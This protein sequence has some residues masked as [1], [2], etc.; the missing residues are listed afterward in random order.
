MSTHTVPSVADNDSSNSDGSSAL[1]DQHEDTGLPVDDPRFFDELGI[2]YLERHTISGS[3]QAAIE[4]FK[5]QMEMTPAEQADLPTVRDLVGSF[6]RRFGDSRDLD[7]L[8]EAIKYQELAL[9][10]TP[11]GHADLPTRL[12]NLGLSFLRRFENT[13]DLKDISAAI[14]YQQRAL[15]LTPVGHA[16][17]P[18]RFNNLGSSFLQRFEQNGDLNDVSE[19]IKYQ[20]RALQLI[21]DGHANLPAW[22]SNCGLSFLRR[23]NHAGNLIDISEAITYQQRA[24]KLT[25]DGHP[26][27]PTWLSNLGLSFSRRFEHTGDL[28]NLSEAIKYQERALQLTPAGHADLPTKLCNLGVSFLRRFEHTT[29][30]LN[31]ISEAIKYHQR[32]LQLTSEGPAKLQT[33]LNNLGVS[34]VCRFGHTG[35]LNDISEAIKYQQHSLQITP[36]GHS[37]LPT[38]L[39]NLGV[40][41]LRRFEH[42]GDLNDI[43]E[44][45]KYKQRALQLAPAG[46]AHLPTWLSNLGVSFS[47]RFER[48]GDLNDVSEAIKSHQRAL[49]LTPDG[50]AKLPNWL[51]HLGISFSRRF[52]CT[53][54]LNDISEAIKYQ[55]RALQ[56]IPDEHAKLPDWLSNLGISFSL[57]FE[58]TGDLNDL[59][60]AIKY[61]EHAL[62]LTPDGHAKLPNWLSNLGLS[63]LR[64]FEHTGDLNHISNAIKYYRRAVQLTPAGH[65]DLPNRLNSLGLSFSHHFE[66]SGDLQC[67]A[68]AESN[69]RLSATS[70]I[71]P[72][73]VRLLAAKRWA[74]L[75]RM[76][77]VPSSHLLDAHACIIELLTLVSGLETTVQRRHE[78][79]VDSSQ[80][81]TAA[82]AAALSL[83]HPDKA[84]E[85]LVEG[86]C[87]IWNQINQ[88]RTPVD[89]LRAH[90]RALADRFSAVSME[91][92]VAGSRSESRTISSETSL[93]TEDK[94]S[95]E[96]QA[97]KH[98]KLAKERDQL[99][100]TIRNIPSFED[101][102]RPKKCADIIRD[103]PEEG[104]SVIINIHEDRCDALAL[105]AGA[106]EPMHIPLPK[107]SY[108]EAECLA[109]GL[110]DYL[111]HCGVISRKIMLLKDS[112]NPSVCGIDLA[113]VLSVLWSKVVL[114]ILESLR[115]NL[116]CL[117]LS[118]ILMISLMS[119]LQEPNSKPCAKAMPRIWWCPTG[120]LAFLPIHAAGIYIR[121]KGIATQCLAD[122][123][124]SSYI[125]TVDA[126]LKTQKSVENHAE[127]PTGLL[128]V[129]QPNTPK[130][131]PILGAADEANRIAGQLEKRGIPSLTLVDQS[132]TIKS[133]SDAMA[134]F[135]CIHLACHAMQNT[136]SPLKTSIFL[137]DGPFELSEIMKKNLPNSD[138]AFLSACQ[139]STGDRNLPEEVVHLAAGMLAAGYRSV[140]GTTWSIADVHGPEIA[141]YFYESLLDDSAEGKIDGAGAAWALHCATQLFQEKLS[142]H[143]NSLLVWV[144]YIHIGI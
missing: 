126:L 90:D 56:L 127:A 117:L 1:G 33:W 112:N 113:D 37:E 4:A 31:D 10:L 93:V 136:T 23:F 27:L 105:V 87:I 67:F 122:F 100:V 50:H 94:I 78:T 70:S 140:V 132:G 101:F 103:L 107:F 72:P 125:P 137:Y 111:H 102:L 104:T 60:E 18:T 116:V 79:L 124:V 15:Q 3:L 135:S 52:K 88:L 97:G 89:E 139:T 54:D 129:S 25:P 85:W 13:V 66:C 133:V 144:P 46:H 49:Q 120:P 106:N 2:Y 40:S 110:Q 99:L 30:D 121:S 64:G 95:L 119:Y 43:S 5:E 109:K 45:I 98:I 58:H 21:P 47:R 131:L 12:S 143:H 69:Y 44:A 35:D 75:I 123:A 19:A 57:R 142:D 8:S 138:F 118:R 11:D 14:N 28:N 128:I 115:L 32:A 86:R 71:G 17:L 42:T 29:G 62:R 39:S 7:D 24:L 61:Q 76:S 9:Q 51:S 92:E 34:F 83:G 38:G 68:D 114:P 82:A 41:F 74:A 81:S 141:E 48:T 26:D 65:A 108:K 6:S 134:S 77:L 55:Q 84:L 63:F 16:N 59:S 73:S 20:Q 80:L 96:E 22:L 36:D 91:L 53:G 130:Q